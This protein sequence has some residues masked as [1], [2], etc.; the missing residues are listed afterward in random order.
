MK[1]NQ[2]LL[3]V[4]LAGCGTRVPATPAA[5]TSKQAVC[6]TAATEETRAV[7]EGL[8]EECASCHSSGTRGFFASLGAFQELLVADRALLTPGSP[9]E[10]ELV[11]LLEGHGTGPFAQM[12]I[13]GKTYAQ[14][15]EGKPG[16]LQMASIRSWVTGL[17]TQSRDPRPNA[18]TTR[19]TRISARQ[20][21]RTLY[22]QLGLTNDDFYVE[23]SE[24]SLPMAQARSDDAYPLLPPDNIPTP[25][26]NPT[27]ERFMALGGGSPLVQ[28]GPDRGMNPTFA[29]TLHQTSQAWCRQ[30]LLKPGNV[31]LFPSGGPTDGTPATAKA[32]IRR[33]ARHFLGERFTDT[34]VDELHST[35]FVPLA[36]ETNSTNAYTGVCSFFIRHPLWLYN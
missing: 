25:R 19:I 6:G 5:A 14:R 7:Y 36:T 33:W 27:V 34:D 11:K 32:T 28:R 12:P 10:S 30:A 35:L 2:L 16:L 9:D 4:A 21:Q 24:F 13:A 31:V 8:K 22:Q 1:T 23:A 17:A 26:N 29:L 20:L 18:A 15:V 3:F